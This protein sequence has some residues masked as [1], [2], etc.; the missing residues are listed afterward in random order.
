M[1]EI[2]DQAVGG[3]IAE[4]VAATGGWIFRALSQK[5]LTSNT[6]ISIATWFDTHQLTSIALRNFDALGHAETERLSDAIRSDS[7]QAIIH[8]LLALRMSDGTDLDV[9]RLRQAMQQ[10]ILVEHADKLFEQI[11]EYI[12]GIVVRLDT[13]SP[14]VLEAIRRDAFLT[15]IG[16]VVSAIERHVK[17]LT[18]ESNPLTDQEYIS[19]YRRL[20]V[21]RYGLIEPPD[22]QR[23]RQVSISKLYVPPAIQVLHGEEGQE[24]EAFDTWK[25]AEKVDRTVLLGD[26]GGGK[27]TACR[28]LMHHHAS[29]ASGPLPFLVTVRMF[30]AEDPPARSVVDYIEN[31]LRTYYQCSP[32]KG[33]LDR[34]LLSGSALIIFDGL[35]ELLDA[36]RRAEM[37]EIVENFAMEY[38]LARVLVTSRSVGYS[39][40][41]L[42]YQQFTSYKVNGFESSQIE[43]YSRKWFNQENDLTKEEARRTAAAFV[44]ESECVQDLRSNP[45]MLALMCI[46]YRG[47]GSIPRNRPEIYGECANLLFRK[48]DARRKI[49]VEIKARHLVEPALRYIAFWLFTSGQG[50]QGVT[51]RQLIAQTAAYFSQRGSYENSFEAEEAAAQFVSFCRGR[52]WVFSDVGTT[53]RGEDLYTFTHRTFM[54]YFAAYH[55]SS[56]HEAPEKLAKVLAP[57]LAR[58]E[59]EV[60]AQLAIQ[61]KHYTIDRGGE[62]VCVSLLNEKIRRNSKSR[63]NILGFVARCLSFMDPPPFLVRQTVNK[64]VGHVLELPNDANQSAPLGDLLAYEEGVLHGQVRNAIYDT[65]DRMANSSDP[66]EQL[67]G[68][69][70][71]LYLIW[72]D[73]TIGD[74]SHEWRKY[75]GS[76]AANYADTVASFSAEHSDLVA[77]IPA[78]GMVPSTEDLLIVHER[79]FL[80]MFERVDLNVFGRS[81][82]AHAWAL[83]MALY[84]PNLHPYIRDL[85]HAALVGIA[86]FSYRMG[87]PP[88]LDLSS[89][90]RIEMS[91]PL[92]NNESVQVPLDN[93][94]QEGAVILQIIAYELRLI[95]G[96]KVDPRWLIADLK[97]YQQRREAIEISRLSDENIDHRESLPDLGF[98]VSLQRYL[99]EWAENKLSFVSP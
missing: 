78:L 48:W 21:K 6:D 20:A 36:R 87:E 66:E 40:A 69:R 18:Q 76:W 43:E 31:R 3:V 73:P 72:A 86:R 15:R 37:T 24:P 94:A 91:G 28:V 9:A 54:E 19:R 39:E 23:R 90:V 68:L 96:Q 49:H 51:Q 7:F 8:E 93:K 4:V 58:N 25:L 64:I 65:F 95:E 81:F 63:G 12:C 62:R 22:F 34:L 35:D 11:D 79:Q 97:F 84:S 53:E 83:L 42:D 50:S 60:V 89:S 71:G 26:P 82:N 88:W 10:V 92:L 99:W 80:P 16:A 46:L 13:Q 41:P 74:S 14:Q 44:Q 52:G 32:P 5:K 67:L 75:A 56:I 98:S 85:V 2:L 1:S 59:W 17:V 47:S 33:L 55:L 30:A 77:M 45:L 57:H 27:T 38:P 29:I 70:L 61:I